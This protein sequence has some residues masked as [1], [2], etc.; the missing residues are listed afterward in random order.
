MLGPSVPPYLR[1]RV[2]LA[3]SQWQIGRHF[4]RTTR[5]TRHA[6]SA[7]SRAG[8]DREVCEWIARGRASFAVMDV[9]GCLIV[10]EVMLVYVI[11]TEAIRR[12]RL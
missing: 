8:Y 9:A 1:T 12:H 7:G 11:H 2:P 6:R 4:E 10:N 5:L 3:P